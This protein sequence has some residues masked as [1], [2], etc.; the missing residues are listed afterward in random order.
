MEVGVGVRGEVEV[1]IRIRV[2]VDVGV[3]SGK[4]Q[5]SKLF[6]GTVYRNVQVFGVSDIENSF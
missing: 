5:C 4:L 3:I 2:E 6:I 1:E